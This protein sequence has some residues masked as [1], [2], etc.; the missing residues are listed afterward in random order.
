MDK[1]PGPIHKTNLL[2]MGFWLRVHPGFASMR[3]FHTQLCAD[4]RGRYG[5]IP[6]LQSLNLPDNFAEPEMYFQPGKLRGML[7]H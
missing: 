6:D 4:L 2:H 5:N 1:T 7:D 3:A